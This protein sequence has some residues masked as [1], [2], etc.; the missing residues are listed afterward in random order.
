[1]RFTESIEHEFSLSMKWNR[2]EIKEGREDKTSEMNFVR[3]VFE[4]W[5]HL[6]NGKFQCHN[7]CQNIVFYILRIK[8]T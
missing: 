4:A 3:N 6:K 8:E 5:V 2:F 1:M 7:F